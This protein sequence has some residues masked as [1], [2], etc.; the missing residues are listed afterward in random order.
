[1]IKIIV[2]DVFPGYPS[3]D[4]NSPLTHPENYH[5]KTTYPRPH[6]FIRNK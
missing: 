3:I 4:A 6:R 2:L 5:E 1:M